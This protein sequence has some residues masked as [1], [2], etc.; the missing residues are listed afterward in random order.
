MNYINYSKKLEYI[1]VLAL[2]KA[3][4]TCKELAQ[5]LDVSESTIKRMIQCLREKG[6]AIRY[7][8]DRKTYFI[9]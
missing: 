1:Q 5:R 4:G 9:E 7:S 2:K 3:T 8:Q 6:V